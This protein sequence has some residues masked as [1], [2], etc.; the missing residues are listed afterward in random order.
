MP[1]RHTRAMPRP[2]ACPLQPASIRGTVLRSRAWPS[3]ACDGHCG[4]YGGRHAGK[5]SAGDRLHGRAQPEIA[6]LLWASVRD[7]RTLGDPAEAP[8]PPPHRPRC[9]RC[10]RAASRRSS[11]TANWCWRSPA[12]SSS[13]SSSA[14]AKGDW[15]PRPARPNACATAIGAAMD[16]RRD[17]SDVDRH[18]PAPARRR[19]RT[20]RRADQ[21][22]GA[23]EQDVHEQ[24]PCSGVSIPPRK[25]R[26]AA[27]R[28]PARRESSVCANILS[29]YAA[30]VVS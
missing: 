1:C 29:A 30:P 17:R 4:G 11:P 10:I 13:I 23:G 28:L 22:G 3:D 15:C 19:R 24:P 6:D 7:H 12:A 27:A 26:T 21:A 5:L 2:A 16:D 25:R 20:Q 18:H 9:G 8:T 14:T